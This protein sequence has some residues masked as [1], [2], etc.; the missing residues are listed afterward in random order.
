M[1]EKK[2][3]QRVWRTRSIKHKVAFILMI[4]GMPFSHSP[5]TGIEFAAPASY[6][7][8]MKERLVNVYGA[9]LEPIVEEVR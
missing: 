7:E 5:E 8:S 4:D 3:N 9:S 1:A 6:V 2:E